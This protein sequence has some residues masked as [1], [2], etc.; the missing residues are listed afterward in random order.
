MFLLL[1][2]CWDLII[3]ESSENIEYCLN[4]PENCLG[5]WNPGNEL[6]SEAHVGALCEQCDIDN[7]RG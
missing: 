6:C 2:L 5:G 3:G 7:I 4:M 1:E